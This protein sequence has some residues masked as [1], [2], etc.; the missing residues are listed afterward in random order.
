MLPWILTTLVALAAVYGGH[1]LLLA[2]EKFDLLDSWHN[3]ASSG[4]ASYNPLLEIYQPQ[5]QHVV[6]VAEQRRENDDDAG[7]SPPA[8][9]DLTMASIPASGES[10]CPPPN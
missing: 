4:G 5:V 7:D 10:P 6:Q 8:G 3:P 9:V 2:L 1:R